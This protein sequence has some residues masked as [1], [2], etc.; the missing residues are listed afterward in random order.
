MKRTPAGG[1][2]AEGQ[3]Y[4]FDGAQTT[5]IAISGSAQGTYTFGYDNNGFLTSSKLVSGAQTVT[6]ALTRDKDGRLTGDGPFVDRPRRA[7][8]AR[9]ARSPAAA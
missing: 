2:T 9:P 4:T 3:A 5:G 6:T 7:S 8:A 1:G